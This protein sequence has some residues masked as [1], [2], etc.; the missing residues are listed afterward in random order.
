MRWKYFL[1]DCRL[2]FYFLN[3][4]LWL[5]NALFQWSSIYLCTSNQRWDK[6]HKYPHGFSSKN[7]I[8][9]TLTFKYLTYAVSHAQFEAVLIYLYWLFFQKK[10]NLLHVVKW[11]LCV[12]CLFLHPLK[13]SIK[14][15]YCLLT[16][17][18]FL[19]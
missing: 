15:H 12:H 4:V 18:G 7:F 13:C 14:T 17:L 5:A 16:N 9:L 11:C 3:D 8:I 2:S 19:K 1:S 6:G 10:K